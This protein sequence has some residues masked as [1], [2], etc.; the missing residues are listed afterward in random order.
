MKL[1]L[2]NILIVFIALII[3]SSPQLPAQGLKPESP[4]LLADAVWFRGE[5][6]S[7]NRLD[8]YLAVPFAS[9]QFVKSGS[10][11][12]AEYE[13]VI[14][15]R[16]SIG[17]KIRQ[18]NVQRRCTAL[19]YDA[20]RGANGAADYSQTV[21]YLPNGSN[22]IEIIAADAASKRELRALLTVKIPRYRTLLIAES[23]ILLVSSIEERGGRFVI[24]PYLSPNIGR[25]TEPFFAFFETY[26]NTSDIDEADFVYELTDA[27][28]NLAQRGERTR[29]N[30]KAD[31][32]RHYLPVPPQKTLPAGDYTLR[33][34][35]LKPA[36]G[37]TAA[38][39]SSDVLAATE[40]PVN[41]GRTASDAT[42]KELDN[43]IR[44][45]LY[46]AAQSEIDRI[47]DAAAPD[48]KRR[49]FDEFWRRLDPSPN[50]E[51]NEAFDEY[52]GR[53]E[54]ANRQYRTFREGWLSDMG[55]VS[56]IF[57]A[58]VS[59]DRSPAVSASGRS[60][61]RWTMA[62]NR[63]FTFVDDMGF[64]EYR[65]ATPLPAGEKYRYGR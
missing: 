30:I 2:I 7:A 8:V 29:R 38:Y 23:G 24:T 50:T 28:G 31:L 36:D 10:G 39:K 40:R 6:D 27:K 34:V 13:A 59:I 65:L 37:K 46:V 18:K 48:E 21:F 12:A 60:V 4:A 22:S 58:P 57:G 56:V 9:L 3:V 54:Y 33:V 55:A 1:H 16:D 41:I 17:R 14:T 44:Q 43:M 20:A 15:V 5:A 11:F 32:E 62:N 64:G 35:A 45:L 51:R 42:G 25:L 53:I 19:D 52:Y 49:L 26:N 61:V 63:Q 47:Q